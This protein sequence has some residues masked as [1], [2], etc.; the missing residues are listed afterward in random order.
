MKFKLQKTGQTGN[1]GIKDVEIIVPL[2]C[3]SNIWTAF[4]ISWIECKIIL[5]LTCSEKIILVAGTAA[6]QVPKFRITN[7]SIFL[8]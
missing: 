7:N 3:I 6:N 4:E 8:L 1:G 2:I 5:Q